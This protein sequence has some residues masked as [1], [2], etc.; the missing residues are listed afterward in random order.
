VICIL[1]SNILKI[2]L[3]KNTLESEAQ[4]NI[5]FHLFLIFVTPLNLEFLF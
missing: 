3:I 2:K 5:I 1:F 4:R